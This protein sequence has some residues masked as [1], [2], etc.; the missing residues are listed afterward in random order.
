MPTDADSE[1]THRYSLAVTEHVGAAE[2]VAFL[3]L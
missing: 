3:I 2:K 1:T